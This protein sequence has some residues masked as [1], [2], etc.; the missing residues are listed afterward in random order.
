MNASHTEVR[1]PSSV[2]ALLDERSL[3]LRRRIVRMMVDAGRGHLAPALS[4]VEILRVLYDDILRCDPTNPRWPGRDR[5][6]LSKGHGCMALYVLLAEKGFFPERELGLFCQPKG[7]LGGHPEC[8]R[9]PGVEASTGSLG[10]GPSIGLGFALNARHE[11]TD[12]RVF[13]VI[14]D[15]EANE[16]SVWEAAL[17]CAKHGLDNYTLIIDCNKHQS[18]GP[19]REVLNLEPLASKWQ[20]FG[21]GV[22]EVDGHNVE[23]LRQT[24]L[25]LPVETGKPSA[26]ICHTIK[27]AGIDCVEHNLSWHHKSRLTDDESN[28]LVEGIG[29]ADASDLFESRS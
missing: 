23:D 25:N 8:P 14:G 19:T 11:N 2:C 29:R 12:A 3:D 17:G 10:H 9:I 21:W 13:V 6:I 27:G 4:L 5:F 1:F 20:S 16:G 18:Y 22:A 24:F 7:I 15:G 28:A 26:V